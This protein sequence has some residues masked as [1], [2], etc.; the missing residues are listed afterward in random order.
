MS[1]PSDASPRQ[2]ALSDDLDYEDKHMFPP[3]RRSHMGSPIFSRRS[4]HSVSSSVESSPAAPASAKSYSNSPMKTR[5]SESELLVSPR[6]L[7]EYP[8]YEPKKKMS[9]DFS[10]D[11]MSVGSIGNAESPKSDKGNW[12]IRSAVAG[13][14]LTGP[15]AKDF[16][17]ELKTPRGKG[18]EDMN[19]DHSGLMFPLAPVLDAIPDTPRGGYSQPQ[20]FTDISQYENSSQ[21]MDGFNLDHSGYAPSEQMAF[22]N[23]RRMPAQQSQEAML[24]SQYY[25]GYAAQGNS[26]PSMQQAADGHQYNGASQSSAI[27]AT[28]PSNAHAASYADVVARTNGGASEQSLVASSGSDSLEN[29]SKGMADSMAQILAKTQSGRSFGEV[30]LTTLV[31][32]IHLHMNIMGRTSAAIREDYNRIKTKLE[33]TITDKKVLEATNYH[34]QQLVQQYEVERQYFHQYVL[35]SL[36]SQSSLIYESMGNLSQN[37]AQSKYTIEE[38]S[39]RLSRELSNIQGSQGSDSQLKEV[40]EEIKRAVEASSATGAQQGEA[41][42]HSPARTPQAAANPGSAIKSDE[43]KS[44]GFKLTPVLLAVLLWIATLGGVYFTAKSAALSELQQQSASAASILPSDLDLIVDQIS[45]K[46]ESAVQA[47]EVRK[48]VYTELKQNP[49]IIESVVGSA[50][51][52]ITEEISQRLD[53]EVKADQ[54]QPE[55]AVSSE[56]SASDSVD[57]QKIVGLTDTELVTDAEAHIEIVEDAVSTEPFVEPV[58]PAEVVV[59]APSDVVPPVVAESDSSFVEIEVPPVKDHQQTHDALIEKL[60]H[61]NG[62]PGSES[63]SD[64][65]LTS[66]DEGTGQPPLDVS[67]ATE[68]DLVADKSAESEDEISADKA[69]SS[70]QSV[71]PEAL[72]ESSLEVEAEVAAPAVETEDVIE[73]AIDSAVNPE[74]LIQKEEVLRENTTSAVEPEEIANLVT[75]P[76]VSEEDASDSLSEATAS[77]PV[78]RD[79]SDAIADDMISAVIE[80]KADAVKTADEFI[81]DPV[82]S[83]RE[84]A[85]Y[86]KEED[87]SES[88]EAPLAVDVESAERES[89]IDVDGNSQTERSSEDVDELA[90]L[91]SKAGAVFAEVGKLARSTATSDDSD[92]SMENISL[93][94]SQGDVEDVTDKSDAA[95]PFSGLSMALRS[96]ASRLVDG[97]DAKQDDVIQATTGAFSSSDKPEIPSGVIEDDEPVDSELVKFAD[98][99]TNADAVEG[100]EAAIELPVVEESVALSIESESQDLS[101]K[102]EPILEADS[103]EAEK[104]SFEK[105]AESFNAEVAEI[106]D[107]VSVDSYEAEDTSSVPADQLVEETDV[108]GEPTNVDYLQDDMELVQS[109]DETQVA[110][111][112]VEAPDA[113]AVKSDEEVVSV[114]VEATLE[115]DDTIDEAQQVDEVAQDVEAASLESETSGLP[116]FDSLSAEVEEEKVELS[117]AAIQPSEAVDAIVEVPGATLIVPDV[118]EDVSSVVEDALARNIEAIEPA[119][120]IDS[121]TEFSVSVEGLSEEVGSVDAEEVEAES[122]ELLEAGLLET[123][124]LV[125][126]EAIDV[127]GNIGS[128][129]EPTLSVPIEET[130]EAAAD[131]VSETTEAEAGEFTIVVDE[132]EVAEP[133]VGEYASEDKFEV[134]VGDAAE[135]VL[136]DAEPVPSAAVVPGDDSLAESDTPVDTDVSSK[137]D[138]ELGDISIVVDNIG[139]FVAGDAIGSVEALEPS[140]SSE[141]NPATTSE[142]TDSSTASVDKLEQRESE[143]DLSAVD[144]V[145]DGRTIAAVVPDVLSEQ[146]DDSSDEPQSEMMTIVYTDSLEDGEVSKTT[147]DDIA[148]EADEEGVETLNQAEA[149]GDAAADVEEPSTTVDATEELPAASES[150]VV[151]AE[152]VNGDASDLLAGKWQTLMPL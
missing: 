71:D 145:E 20:G 152:S 116:T 63:S 100:A 93:N 101:E 15:L 94:G 18:R 34:L 73:V 3:S 143:S 119:E 134:P 146:L 45:R 111:D 36:Q 140:Q 6:N 56:P 137:P 39:A 13:P 66:A 4:V 32:K 128:V 57:E 19:F 99:S 92:V 78:T 148:Y 43:N 109:V 79:V 106:V 55:A 44:S 7:D 142:A 144:A 121:S 90:A 65:V 51:N 110:A 8:R 133:P 26:D 60:L 50:G 85:E 37:V 25:A 113:V 70:N 149:E 84:E 132:S 64:V 108:A 48:L 129:P 46:L 131:V 74:L 151:P 88:V 126:T 135:S 14:F 83:S 33:Q 97:F 150:S 67:G 112:S 125:I 72:D 75:L 118:S 120:S 141:T 53:E 98:E 54:H 40:L 10:D 82:V 9:A 58:A 89:S 122:K 127:E 1:T 61:L 17:T 107:E 68:S 117:N 104:K 24:N 2:A 87:P 11:T 96:L 31:Q 115:A 52:G 21:S 77:E 35:H 76:A 136:L 41:R 5:H 47:S 69:E 49:Q 29:L 95:T 30:Q 139:S 28:Q 59:S 38:L 22:N 103:V 147:G 27:V 23:A 102:I 138:E 130:I 91:E 124:D 16:Q 62:I 114:P 86:V 12:R 105:S 81:V 80:D 42:S 123:T